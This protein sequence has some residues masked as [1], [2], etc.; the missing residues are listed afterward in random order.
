MKKIIPIINETRHET[1]IFLAH[2][3]KNKLVFFKKVDALKK[4]LDAYM[5]KEA[6]LVLQGQ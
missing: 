1:P 3:E 2:L 6:K 5:F 4:N